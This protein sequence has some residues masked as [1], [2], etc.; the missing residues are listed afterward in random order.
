MTPENSQTTTQI[1]NTTLPKK[2]LAKATIGF[3][4]IRGLADPMFRK[5]Y[6]DQQRKTF[7]IL[8]LA[9]TGVKDARDEVGWGAD[10]GRL[11]KISHHLLGIRTANK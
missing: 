1:Q 2:P 8:V 10:S 7:D 5:Q 4:N 11:E 9:E 6:L 3:H